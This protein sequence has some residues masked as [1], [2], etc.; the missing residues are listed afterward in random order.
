MVINTFPLNIK[1]L[2][3]L[4]NN[5]YSIALAQRKAKTGY[6]KSVWFLRKAQVIYKGLAS[7]T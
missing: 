1:M 5:K 4:H 2:V 6:K 7:C 3:I